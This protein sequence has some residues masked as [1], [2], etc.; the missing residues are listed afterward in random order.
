[1]KFWAKSQTKKVNSIW[2][3]GFN[4]VFEWNGERIGYPVEIAG[5]NLRNVMDVLT[6]DVG[7]L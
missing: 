1:M 5:L 2:E 7:H 4:S 3:D 6:R